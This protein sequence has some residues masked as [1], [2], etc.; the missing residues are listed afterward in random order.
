M[1]HRVLKTWPFEI[2]ALKVLLDEA[3]ANGSWD[4]ADQLLQQAPPS[5]EDFAEFESIK[6]SIQERRIHS[7][8]GLFFPFIGHRN[9]GGHLRPEAA[10]RA[11]PG[12]FFI[13]KGDGHNVCENSHQA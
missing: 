10:L 8:E 2:S 3:I 1:C 12:P 5:F 4:D 11:L 7:F 9:L 6:L 13:V